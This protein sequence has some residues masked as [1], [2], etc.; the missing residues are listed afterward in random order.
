VF[1]RKLLTRAGLMVG[2][3]VALILSVTSPAQ[4]HVVP[5]STVVLEVH[6]DVTDAQL[7]IPMMD[8]VDASGI[9]LGAGTEED[10][11][12]HEAEIVAYIQ[13]HFTPESATGGPW[14]VSVDD[15]GVT[16]TEGLGTGT[17]DVLTATA[18]LVA[19]AGADTRKFNLGYDVVVHQVVTHVAMVSV[20]YDWSNGVIESA[21]QLGTIQLDSASG[22]TNQLQ[23]D[24]GTPSALAGFLGMVTLGSAHI[25]EG[26]DHQLFLLALLLPAGLLLTGRRWGGP[27]TMRAAFRKIA[28]ITLAFT[29]GHS[30]TLALGALGVPVPEELVEATIALSIIVAAAHAL[31]PLFPGKE[32][33]IAG[34]FGLVHGMAF[35]VTLQ[36]LQLSGGQLA[37]SLLGFNI[38]IELMQL[39]VVALV[40]PPLVIIARTRVHAP[41]RMVAA[42]VTIIAATGWLVQ[43]LGWDNPIATMADGIGEWGPLVVAALWL[44][45]GWVIVS[46]KMPKVGAR[47]PAV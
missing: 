4:A 14:S 6:D 12:T 21:R 24:L 40:L 39:L 11:A 16:T 10:V 38:G 20:R 5:T 1:N 34:G 19:P 17:Y 9:D 41:L 23:I 2:L 28:W 44:M 36:E 26:V 45:A 43:R 47:Q 31:Y 3:I 32:V 46:Q 35:S 42:G 33:L 30:I 22:Q 25:R 27:T 18:H 29:V 7:Q 13:Q 15:L 37:L 8:L